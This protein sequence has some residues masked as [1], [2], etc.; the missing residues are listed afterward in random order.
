MQIQHVRYMVD[1]AG[2]HEVDCRSGQDHQGSRPYDRDHQQDRE[3][4]AGAGSG[5]GREPLLMKSQKRSGFPSIRSEKSFASR[6]TPSRSK[7][8]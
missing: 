1:K 5:L 3:G 7:R 4:L 2:D 6:R 8:R